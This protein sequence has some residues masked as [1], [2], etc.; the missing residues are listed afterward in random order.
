LTAD[1]LGITSADNKSTNKLIDT[2]LFIKVY[3][4]VVL[5]LIIKTSWV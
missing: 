3:L 2:I 4:S 1:A 5:P